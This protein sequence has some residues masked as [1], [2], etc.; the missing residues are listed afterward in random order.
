MQI[1]LLERVK[2]LG[3]LGDVVNVKP[4]YARN[5]LIPFGKAVSATKDNIEQFEKRRAEL[6]EKAHE[7]HNEAQ[8]RADKLQDFVLEISKKAS[9]E[10]RLYGSVA[11]DDVAQAIQSQGV[12]VNKKEVHLPEGPIRYTGEHT[13]HLHFHS[14]VIV[15]L[16]VSV[17]S[18]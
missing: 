4:G 17:Q 18:E 15:D 3:H 16:S 14:D 12:T 9:E 8:R 6:E 10:G 5:Y 1:V 11:E 2:N 13:V 7:L